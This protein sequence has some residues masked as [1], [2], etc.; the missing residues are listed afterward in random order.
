[1]KALRAAGA[2]SGV[3]DA[4]GGR[5]VAVVARVLDVA[6]DPGTELL[7]ALEPG[8]LD[9]L[10]PADDARS[11]APQD[12]RSA[13]SAIIS[14]GNTTRL[15]MRDPLVLLARPPRPPT[16]GEA[17]LVL[18]VSMA[19]SLPDVGS[20]PVSRPGASGQVSRRRCR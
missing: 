1:M 18:W 11:V 7:V 5:D 12:A 17:I 9:E 16:R 2:A 15:T 3:S 4:G 19:V 14:A 13:E 20:L 10:V 6:D 8:P